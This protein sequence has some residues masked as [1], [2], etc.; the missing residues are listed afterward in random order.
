MCEGGTTAGRTTAGGAGERRR[1]HHHRHG[2]HADLPPPP[3]PQ[4]LDEV[5]PVAAL[6]PDGGWQP[7][8]LK[9]RTPQHLGTLVS[10]QHFHGPPPFFFHAA[11][12][13]GATVPGG[14]L[15]GWSDWRLGSRRGSAGRCAEEKKEEWPTPRDGRHVGF[16]WSDGDRPDG[17]NHTSRRT[18]RA[19]GAAGR[20]RRRW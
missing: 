4:A 20:Q 8:V 19:A 3:T 14:W 6:T 13:C 12:A 17:S 7:A 15:P 2:R 5:P 1:S 18:R 10:Q 11:R 16:G 9:Y